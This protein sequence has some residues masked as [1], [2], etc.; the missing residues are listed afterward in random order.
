M[1]SGNEMA[2]PFTGDRTGAANSPR[3][4]AAKNIA[5]RGGGTPSE[6][7]G[8]VG[9]E[10]KRRRWGSLDVLDAQ[11]QGDG[12]RVYGRPG[13]GARVKGRQN[14]GRKLPAQHRGKKHRH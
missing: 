11:R 6:T 13:D 7:G 8:L 3:S 10:S 5:I 12:V 2:P 14:R 1:P 4:I 9:A